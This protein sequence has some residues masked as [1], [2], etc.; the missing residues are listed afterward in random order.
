MLRQKIIRVTSISLVF[1]SL[2]FSTGCGGT[3]PSQ[4]SIPT[5]VPS[6]PPSNGER[7]DGSKTIKVLCIDGG[8]IRGIIPAMLLAE[9]EKRTQKPISELFNL[10]VGTSTGGILALALTKPNGQGKPQYTAK[11]LI[12]LYET[13]GEQIF[14][15]SVWHRIQS[16]ANFVGKKYPADGIEKVLDHYFEDAR[17][18]DA[19]TEVFIPSYDIER[20]APFF[21]QSRNAKLNR[22]HD[23]KMKQVA[24]ATTTAPTYFEPFKIEID[25]SD[26]VALIDGGVFANN[27]TLCGFAE[28]KSTHPE[29]DDFLVVSLGTGEMTRRFLY[30]EV[31]GWGLA[32][33]A[34]PILNVVFDGVSDVVDYQM[35]TLLPPAPDGTKRYYRFQ[36]KLDKGSEDLD[37]ANPANVRVLKLLAED[38]IHGNSDTL[39]LLCEQLVK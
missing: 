25:V 22:S 5:T 20:R 10:I 39:T 33:W 14:S 15:R 2:V 19:L 16:G 32:Q 8:G 17:L 23:F 36:A 34:Q 35:K 26:Y 27:P 7:G 37:N 6:H 21:F 30:D 9:I 24:R 1:I 18:K 4:P 38:V 13:D 3:V 12:G 31:K 29:A 11:D 28:V